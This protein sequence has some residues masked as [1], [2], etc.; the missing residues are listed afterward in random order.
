[1]ETQRLIVDNNVDSEKSYSQ[2]VNLLTSGELVA[3]PTETVYGLGAVATNETAVKKIYSA[4]GRPSDN[5]LIVHIGTFDE[6]ENYVDNISYKARKCMDAFWPGPLTMI[7]KA[8]PNVLAASVTAGLDTVGIRMPNHPVALKLLQKLGKPVAAPSANRSGKPSPTEGVHVEQDLAGKIPMI[9]DGG[10]TGIGV[11]STVIDLTLETPVILRPGAITKEMFESVIGQVKQPTHIEQK[12]GA[13]RA[14]GMKYTHYAPNAPVYLIEQDEQQVLEAIKELQQQGHKVALLAPQ[15]FEHLNSDWFFTF[16]DS[17]QDMAA[18]LF[19][20]L[21]ACDLTAADIVLAT[22]TST[23]GVGAAI[24]N[25]LEKSAGS[26]WYI[27]DFQK[28]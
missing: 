12:A 13:P 10:A 5:P 19:H 14:P 28:Q 8:K 24:M 17:K 26:K 27:K 22:V 23:D 16:G 21:R 11:E 2:A 18:N 1:M 15:S 20:A 25:R 3:F 4:K 6:L 9:L 7:F